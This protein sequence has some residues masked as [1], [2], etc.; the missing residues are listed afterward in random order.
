MKRVRFPEARCSN[1][2]YACKY[3]LKVGC[4][5]SK[6]QLVNLAKRN[7]LAETLMQR[8]ASGVDS[9]PA[10]SAGQL[11]YEAELRRRP[12]YD[13]GEPRPTW[14]QLGDGYAPGTREVIRQS[15]ETVTLEEFAASHAAN[16]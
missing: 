5:P 16:R 13:G 8:L 15:W 10:K 2:G 4:K 1:C 9:A 6:R 3:C 12:N 11:A 7:Q 14:E